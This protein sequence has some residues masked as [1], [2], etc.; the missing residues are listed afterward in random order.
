MRIVKDLCHSWLSEEAPARRL[1]VVRILVGLYATVFVAIRTFHWLDVARLP[2]RRF[3][4]VGVLGGLG[5]PL[6]PSTV[7]GLSGMALLTAVAFTLG[8]RFRWVA[9]VFASLL[10]VLTTHGNSWGQIL[11]TENLLVLHVIILAFSPAD[12]AFAVGRRQPSD[13]TPRH[14]Y[15][16]ALRIMTLV[17]VIAY[18]IAG[19]A[20]LRNG[21]FD[22]L[23]GDVLRNQVAHDNLRKILLGDIYSP[24]GAWLV[25]CAWL[26]PPMA[27]A[28]VLVEL[29]APV[30]LLGDRWKK[31][32]AGAA[33]AFH[34]GVLAFMAILFP[35]PISGIA[36]VSMLPVERLADRVIGWR[37]RAGSDRPVQENR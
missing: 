18:V 8:W 6:S 16:W 2:V 13:D 35:Y 29:G 20:K 7:A 15:G 5:G 27:I 32:W 14:D 25:Q 4:P 24:V 34:V 19:L 12:V 17:V 36:F 26:F 33:W 37:N 21:G 11:H 31:A 10:L 28:S 30:A 23:T 3:D 1:A 22:W 9:P